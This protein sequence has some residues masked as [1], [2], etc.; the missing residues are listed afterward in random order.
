[1]I[2]APKL[3]LKTVQRWILAEILGEVPPH[4]AAHGFVAGRSAVTH[5]ELH[6]DRAA[7]LRLDLE[8]FFASVGAG[9][10]YGIWRALGYRRSVAHVLTGLTTNVVPASVWRRLAEATEPDAVQPRFHL[11]RQLATPH[12]P[13]GAPTSPALA[14][15]AS[16]R[17]DRRLSGLASASGLTYS[18]YADDLIF[19]GS[20]RLIRRGPQFEAVVR[21]IVRDEGFRLN[22]AK[23]ATQTTA[24]RQTVCGVVVNAH[25]NVRRSEY[26]ELRAILHNAARSGPAGQNR[27]EL[28]DFRAHLLGRISWVRALNPT[29][30]RRLDELYTAIDW[31]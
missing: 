12:L 24:G 7:V 14:N 13:Q 1:M 21:E 5:A 3:R 6:T 28:E 25:T 23:T 30:A 22:E 29:R 8:D 17:L 27:D 20:A 16:F 15:L 18:R 10:V 11:G 2:E 4:A 26:D 9:R 31:S 19:S